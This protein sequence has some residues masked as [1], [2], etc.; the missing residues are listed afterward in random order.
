MIWPVGREFGGET[1]ETRVRGF[2]Y[3]RGLNK[4]QYYFGGGWV[5]GVLIINTV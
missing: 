3:Y 2:A 1:H 5:G 4:Y